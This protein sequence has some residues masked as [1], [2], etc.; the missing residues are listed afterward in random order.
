MK[1]AA[2]IKEIKAAAKARGKT[3]EL[4]R[5]GASHEVWICNDIRV[6]VPRHREI[7]PLT[8]RLIRTELEEAL[9]AGWWR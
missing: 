7:T 2:L 9:G 1:R 4:L 5:Q 8:E 3:F 6:P